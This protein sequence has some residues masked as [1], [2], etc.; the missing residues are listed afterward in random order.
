MLFILGMGQTPAQTWIA[1][2]EKYALLGLSVKITDPS[3]ARLDLSPHFQII[4]GSDFR[5]PNEWREWL[6]SI[7]VEEVEACDLFIAAKLKSAAPDVLDGENILLTNRLWAFYRG[8]LLS[9][10]FATAEKP[11]ILTGSCRDGEI[12][13]RQQQDIDA[14][15]P[16]DFRPRILLPTTSGKR[17]GSLSGWNAWTRHDRAATAGGSIAYCTSI[18]RSGPS[19]TS[20]SAFTSM[21]AVSTASSCVIQESRQSSSRAAANNLSGHVTMI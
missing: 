5:I 2:G 10:T 8:L 15:V 13:F 9:S 4:G 19:G 1:D 7:R 18:A 12:G 20:W 11:V 3:I 16:N 14:P 6:G 21:P 17:P